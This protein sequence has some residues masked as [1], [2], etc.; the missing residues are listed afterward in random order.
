[1]VGWE[2][3]KYRTPKAFLVDT[4]KV[5]TGRASQYISAISLAYF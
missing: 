2:E 3:Y 4:P 1:M 5:N